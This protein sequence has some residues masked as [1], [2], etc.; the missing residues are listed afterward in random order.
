MSVRISDALHGRLEGIREILSARSGTRVTTSEAAKHILEFAHEERLD[1]IERLR[2]PTSSL[3]HIRQRYEQG[4]DLSKADWTCLV[5]F[6]HQSLESANRLNPYISKHS[7]VGLVQAF[8]AIYQL[9]P[10][11]GSRHERYYLGHFGYSMDVGN[12]AATNADVLKAAAKC[13]KQIKEIKRPYGPSGLGR[14]LYALVEGERFAD[15]S[16]LNRVLKPF[17]PLLWRLAA[18]GH[19]ANCKVPIRA[20]LEPGQE[21]FEERSFVPSVSEPI[22]DDKFSLS[23][24][25]LDNNDLSLLLVLTDRC[26]ALYPMSRYPMI[27]AF[28]AMLDGLQSDRENEH[29]DSPSFFAYTG[30]GKHGLH[31][32]F[33]AKDNGIT[34][35]FSPF[36]WA[37]LKRLFAKAWELPEMSCIWEKLSLEYGE[38]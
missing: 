13:L 27:T 8:L 16:A 35:T 18:R 3:I 4:L 6:V 26:G 22:G 20:A 5:Y 38:L 17:W 24:A 32:G 25:T 36:E 29:W 23:F 37:A 12:G 21:H 31:V 10:Q 28:R 9:L 34:F 33:R 2:E 30:Q 19:F 14:N 11:D 7:L 15:I 1:L